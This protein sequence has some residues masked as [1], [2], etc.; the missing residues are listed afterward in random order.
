MNDTWSTSLTV[1][2]KWPS[3]ISIL[4]QPCYTYTYYGRDVQTNETETME[5]QGQMLNC[6][7]GNGINH[8]QVKL[9]W[10]KNDLQS[11]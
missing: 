10:Y 7:A 6:S 11:N 2:N 4:E 5:L 9:I 1:C 8:S 3:L